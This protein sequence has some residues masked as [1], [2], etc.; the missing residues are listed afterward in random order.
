MFTDVYI[1]PGD[2][3][4]RLDAALAR[5]PVVTLVGAPGVSKS[6]AAHE[7]GRRRVEQGRSVYGLDLADLTRTTELCEAVSRPLGVSQR[8]GDPV[9]AAARAMSAAPG[10]WVLDDADRGV[11][12]VAAALATWLQL[13]PSLRFL[14]TSRE[15]LRIDGEGLVEAQPLSNDEATQLFRVRASAADSGFDAGDAELHPIAQ[16][17]GGNPLAVELAAARVR[18]LGVVALAAR[19][20]RPLQVLESGL[21]G[22]PT[23]RAFLRGALD[24]SWELLDAAEHSVLSQLT[25][26]RGGFTAELAERVVHADEAGPGVGEVLAKLVDRTLVQRVTP[27]GGRFALSAAVREHASERTEDAEAVTARH[28]EAM[29]EL[30]EGLV[31]GI[32]SPLAVTASRGWHEERANLSHAW[33]VAVGPESVARLTEVLD[34]LA[35]VRGSAAERL[36]LLDP[37]VERSQGAP[38]ARRASLLRRRGDAQRVAGRCESAR[39]DLRG[40]CELADSPALRAQIGCSQAALAWMEGDLEGA[41]TAAAEAVDAAA[42]CGAEAVEARAL[43]TRGGVARAAA[44][45]HGPSRS[46]CRRWPGRGESACRPSRRRHCATWRGCAG[47][48]GRSKPRRRCSVRPVLPFKRW[49]S[50]T[51]RPWGATI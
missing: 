25:V 4:A 21:R 36:S 19:L 2:L 11:P 50:P 42:D 40:A 47:S 7:L 33:Q 51:A 1:A 26:F 29:V 39:A 20:T 30:G 9:R 22:R 13:S 18:G 32:D 14:V 35:E 6:R 34:A 12:A 31:R 23:R 27:A 44:T 41:D 10:L 24:V 38:A 8:D 48:L 3:A 43:T 17:L 15:R 45:R 46:C 49:G 16:A 28:V 5:T 37:G